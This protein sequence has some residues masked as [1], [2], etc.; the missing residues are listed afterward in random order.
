MGHYKQLGNADT[1]RARAQHCEGPTCQLGGTW[2]PN[3]NAG[4]SLSLERKGN[5]KKMR[6]SNSLITHSSVL[7]TKSNWRPRQNSC[8]K[9]LVHH[10][11]AHGLA[12]GIQWFQAWAWELDNFF[13]CSTPQNSQEISKKQEKSQTNSS[14]ATGQ[15]RQTM[16]S[17]PLNQIGHSCLQYIICN[18]GSVPSWSTKGLRRDKSSKYAK[19][20]RAAIA[21]PSTDR[22]KRKQQLLKGSPQG[23]AAPQPLKQCRTSWDTFLIWWLDQSRSLHTCHNPGLHF[24]HSR[25]QSGTHLSHLG[26]CSEENLVIWDLHWRQW[27]L[28]PPDQAT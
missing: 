15:N 27:S 22:S 5:N 9:E 4:N 8:H 20:R 17:F 11:A 10:L 28:H 1:E 3:P 14:L 26:W 24:P 23:K 6:K 18:K 12:P 21:L 19:L 2:A 7:F 13:Q 25:W 16:F